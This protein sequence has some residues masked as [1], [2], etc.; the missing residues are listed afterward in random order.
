MT[1]TATKHKHV[2]VRQTSYRPTAEIIADMFRKEGYHVEI[3]D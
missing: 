3:E 2:I 1:I